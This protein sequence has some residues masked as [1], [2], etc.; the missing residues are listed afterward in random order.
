MEDNRPPIRKFTLEID[1]FERLVLIDALGRR[2][3]GVEVVRSFPL[4]DPAR[5]ISIIDAGGKE[6][7]YLNTLDDVEAGLR[8]QLRTKLEEREF[9]PLVKRVVNDPPE[10]EPA[11]WT[12]ETDRGICTFQLE[13]EDDVH[14]HGS[15]LLIVD[16]HGIRFLVADKRSLDAHSRRV[17]ERFF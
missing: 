14:R 15:Q 13:S 7:V 16:S 8:A 17:L 4:T 10:T 9:M 6:I 11:Q 1:A 5:A 3:E 12:V 2:Y